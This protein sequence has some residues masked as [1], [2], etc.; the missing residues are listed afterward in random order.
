MTLK[1]E[2]YA[3]KLFLKNKNKQKRN[4]AHDATSLVFYILLPSH[5]NE[6]EGHSILNPHS[7][8]EHLGPLFQKRTREVR[9]CDV[10][11]GLAPSL[12]PKPS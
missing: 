2:Y 7:G 6:L 4:A 5:V 3:S 1:V 8:Y 9:H 12:H 10:G 11:R